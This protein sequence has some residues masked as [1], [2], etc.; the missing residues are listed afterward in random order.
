MGDAEK[1]TFKGVTTDVDRRHGDPE[2]GGLTSGEKSAV[3]RGY[4]PKTAAGDSEKQEAVQQ[5]AEEKGVTLDKGAGA[6]Q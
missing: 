2:Q 1:G 4:V 3:A 5:L 6:N